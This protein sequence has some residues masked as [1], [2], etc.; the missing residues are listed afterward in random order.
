MVMVTIQEAAEQL[1]QLFDSALKGETV[2]I[3]GD[4]QQQIELVVKEKEIK[5]RQ[6]GSG[7]DGILFIREDFYDPLDDD[8]AEYM[9]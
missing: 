2:V 7:K 3:V 4:N 8:F 5:K 6:F 1:Q 9:E